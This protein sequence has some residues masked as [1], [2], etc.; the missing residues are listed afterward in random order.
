MNQTK[1]VAS[2][3]MRNEISK[4]IDSADLRILSSLGYLFLQKEWDV[5]NLEEDL[6]SDAIETLLDE[7]ETADYERLNH[8][9]SVLKAQNLLK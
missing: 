4:Y 7:I 1:I 9:Y 6:G 8:I 2:V 5:E 3:N